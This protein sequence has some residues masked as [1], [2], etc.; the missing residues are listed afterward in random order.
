MEI[1][2][3]K[4]IVLRKAIKEVDQTV[5]EVNLREPTVREL[6]KFQKDI[7]KHGPINA[8]SLLVAT[9]SGLQKPTIDQM[10][11]RDFKDCQNY[12]ASF[13]EYGEAPDSPETG[14]VN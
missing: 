7:E 5:A 9:I 11:A 2:D 12:L 6:E 4:S 1:P 10:G 8:M 14:E 3:E 13:L